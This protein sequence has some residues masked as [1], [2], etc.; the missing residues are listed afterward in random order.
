MLMSQAAFLLVMMGLDVTKS[1][2]L[3]EVIS[4][5]FCAYHRDDSEE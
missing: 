1:T 3:L 4:I 2:L 5:Y